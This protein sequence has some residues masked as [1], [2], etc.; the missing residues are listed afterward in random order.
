MIALRKLPDV[1][2]VARENL[3]AK[4]VERLGRSPSTEEIN[5]YC[6]E[7]NIT[8]EITHMH[9]FFQDAYEGEA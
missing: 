1:W 4:L 5:E 3:I 2:F 9:H 8:N 7:D 6:S